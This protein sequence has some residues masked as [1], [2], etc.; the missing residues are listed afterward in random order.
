MLNIGFAASTISA[1]YGATAL[2]NTTMVVAPNIIPRDCRA[3]TW[4]G[5][6]HDLDVSNG[7]TTDYQIV[8]WKI[9]NPGGIQNTVANLTCIHSETVTVSATGGFVNWSENVISDTGGY[10]SIMAGSSI[11]FSIANNDYSGT[12][13]NYSVMWNASIEFE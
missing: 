9:D 7:P 5:Y 6:F 11:A 2:A 10:N 8:W 3:V 1:G 13:V 4:S 12:P